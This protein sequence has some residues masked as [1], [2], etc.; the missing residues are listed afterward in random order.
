MKSK[1]KGVFRKL[2][3]GVILAT[4]LTS[5][6]VASPLNASWTQVGFMNGTDGGMFNGNCNLDL[7]TGCTYVT[8][9][10]GDFWLPLNAPVGANEILFI[11]GNEEYWA[12]ADYADVLA[13]SGHSYPA[14]AP[15]NI[16]WIDAGRSGASIVGPVVGNI[17]NRAGNFE[18]PW[19]TLEGA[20]CAL[21]CAEQ[22]WGEND[23][24]AQARHNT[25]RKENA[26]V[27]VYFRTV[28]EPT[29][30]LLLGLGLAGLGFARRRRLND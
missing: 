14:D 6:A 10:V 2:A 12:H 11:S 27:G 26:G 22:L 20:H 17:L 19:V 23:W 5:G 9:S 25:L 18:D 7:T 24:S 4:G 28:P 21:N 30:L 1:K 29:T 15:P 3:I 13:L 8:D 16:T